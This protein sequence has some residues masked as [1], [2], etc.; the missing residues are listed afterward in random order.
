[1]IYQETQEI[2]IAEEPLSI[3][4]PLHK[5]TTIES[6]PFSSNEHQHEVISCPRLSWKYLKK[7]PEILKLYT[8]CPTAA[9]FDLLSIVLSLNIGKSS[10]LKGMK[11]KQQKDTSLAH[12][13]H[14]TR[15]NQDQS[16]N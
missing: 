12:Q 6:N 1:M 16:D 9:T 3:S 8:G 2:K 7:Y 13:S 4:T 10:I 11:W 14:F 15:R 5:P